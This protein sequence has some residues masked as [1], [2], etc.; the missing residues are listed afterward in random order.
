M[1]QFLHMFQLV[2]TDINGGSKRPRW[3]VF[4]RG[5]TAFNQIYGSAFRKSFGIMSGMVFA[6]RCTRSRSACNAMQEVS[7]Q[8]HI[9][10]AFCIGL[11]VPILTALMPQLYYFR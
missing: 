5:Q 10:L 8:D 6:W 1:A 11:S 3:W 9:L 7:F 2:E 4:W